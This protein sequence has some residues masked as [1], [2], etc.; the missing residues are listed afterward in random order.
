M[1]M[2][3]ILRVGES[4]AEVL[5]ERKSQKIAGHAHKK[6][7]RYMYVTRKTGKN[8]VPQISSYGVMH[9]CKGAT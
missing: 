4:Y 9:S 5:G 2:T 7:R 1:L 8:R 6:G 3:E